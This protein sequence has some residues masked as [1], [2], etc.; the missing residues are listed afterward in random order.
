MKLNR[1]LF[2]AIVSFFSVSFVSFLISSVCG[3]FYDYEVLSIIVSG[4]LVVSGILIWL[5]PAI[6]VILNR[7]LK[8]KVIIFL[9]SLTIPIIGGVI[10]Y[11]FINKQL[12]N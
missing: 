1:V 2:Y 11:F 3:L 7:N 8:D 10:S 9:I 4:L 6:I 12:E 5:L